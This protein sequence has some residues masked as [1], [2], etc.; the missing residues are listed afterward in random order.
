MLGGTDK[1]YFKR[2]KLEEYTQLSLLSL[3]VEFMLFVTDH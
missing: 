3:R 1:N 2:R